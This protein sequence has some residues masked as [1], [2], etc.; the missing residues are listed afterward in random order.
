MSCATSPSGSAINRKKVSASPL[1]GQIRPK[2]SNVSS[3]HR[4]STS[5]TNTAVSLPRNRPARPH[6]DPRPSGTVRGHQGRPA[7]RR[8]LSRVRAHQ[9]HRRSRRP[10]RRRCPP[11]ARC[12]VPRPPRTSCGAAPHQSCGPPRRARRPAVGP[13]PRSRPSSEI[14]TSSKRSGRSPPNGSR[15][16]ARSKPIGR[17]ATPAAPRQALQIVCA[18]VEC[19]VDT[20]A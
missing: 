11:R 16:L 17:A 6:R 1:R 2:R 14:D 8:R 4:W 13:A 20:E 9:R 15:R 18:V 3:A 10:S 19:F 5:P 12:S 7:S